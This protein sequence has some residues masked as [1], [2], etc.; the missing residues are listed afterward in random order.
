MVAGSNPAG[1]VG[2]LLL[3]GIFWISALGRDLENV[4]NMSPAARII[5]AWLG[6]VRQVVMSFASSV[7]AGRCGTRSTGCL[8]AAKC[9]RK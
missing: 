5:L 7:H 1:G 2:I 8:M 9:R 3:T 6:T 4:P